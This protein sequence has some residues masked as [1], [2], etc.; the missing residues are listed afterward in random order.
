LRRALP[1]GTV[2]R[3]A[4]TSRAPL[5]LRAAADTSALLAPAYMTAGPPGAPRLL[6]RRLRLNPF[7][8]AADEVEA[9]AGGVDLWF[10]A[11]VDRRSW[12]PGAAAAAGVALGLVRGRPLGARQGRA[13]PGADGAWSSSRRGQEAQH[14]ED[15]RVLRL[16]P[17]V[18]WRLRSRQITS[19]VT[20]TFALCPQG[21]CNPAQLLAA[22]LPAGLQAALWRATGLDVAGLLWAATAAAAGLLPAAYAARSWLAAQ[23]RLADGAAAAVARLKPLQGGGGAAARAA[24]SSRWLSWGLGEWP[25][26]LFDWTLWARTA[27]VAGG[28]NC[29]AAS[30]RAP[31]R[32]AAHKPR[33]GVQAAAAKAT[34]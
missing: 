21:V 25:L 24:A 30:R 17:P 1:A 16:G 15:G 31:S 32:P 12:A 11:A 3:L 8:T 9:Q 7:T 13:G 20:P 22:G 34:S 33:P 26:A 18:H 19:P 29:G 10:A 28:G 6:N 27:A 5:R 23:L 14:R 2:R 4:A